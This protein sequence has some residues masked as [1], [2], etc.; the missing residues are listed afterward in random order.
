LQDHPYVTD[1][2]ARRTFAEMIRYMLGLSRAKDV[3]ETHGLDGA[4]GLAVTVSWR[5]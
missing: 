3:R 1:A 5:P 4:N 2:L